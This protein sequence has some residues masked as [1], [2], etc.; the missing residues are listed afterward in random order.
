MFLTV[1]EEIPEFV[2]KPRE[3]STARIWMLAIGFLVFLFFVATVWPTGDRFEHTDGHL[4]RIDRWSNEAYALTDSGWVPLRSRS[5][6][7]TSATR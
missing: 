1:T 2:E 6:S 7:P 3:I 4:V 5:S